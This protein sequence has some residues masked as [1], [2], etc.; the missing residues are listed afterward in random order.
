MF[1][2][3]IRIKETHREEKNIFNEHSTR[4]SPNLYIYII[5]IH[6]IQ[7][8][9]GTRNIRRVVPTR[10]KKITIQKQNSTRVEKI[11]FK[12]HFF[13]Y[14]A[15]VYSICRSAFKHASHIYN[16]KLVGTRFRNGF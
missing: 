9:A 3:I 10:E 4:A 8:K 14:S 12:V 16:Y 7:C 15:P 5:Y 6:Y 2:N 1:K 13:F 11:C